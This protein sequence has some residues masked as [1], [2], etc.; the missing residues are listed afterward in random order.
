MLSLVPLPWRI[1]AIAFMIASLLGIG[2]TIGSKWTGD[3]DEVRE[4]KMQEGFDAAY[5]RSSA[6]LIA[7]NNAAAAK[8]AGAATGVSSAQSDLATG[9]ANVTKNSGVPDALAGRV[10]MRV[11][12][13]CPDPARSRA[14][15]GAPASATGS[16][17]AAG[18]ELAPAAAGRFEARLDEVTRLGNELAAAQKVIA[19]Y[20]AACGAPASPPAAPVSSASLPLPGQAAV[21]TPKKEL[22]EEDL[23]RKRKLIRLG[24][25]N[26]FKD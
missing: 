22:S 25:P 8:S 20:Y 12:A 11:D 10:R 5:A 3:E 19:T 13:I 26:P 4:G 6:A 15:S 16:D 9:N 18:P 7:A 1:V 21:A 24:L 17:G 23:I 14:V 2:F